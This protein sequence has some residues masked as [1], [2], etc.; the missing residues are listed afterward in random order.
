M[1]RLSALW[2]RSDVSPSTLSVD[3]SRRESVV[4][5]CGGVGGI[6]QPNVGLKRRGVNTYLVVLD[7]LAR[8]ERVYDSKSALVMRDKGIT[9][10][11]DTVVGRV[12]ASFAPITEI[13]GTHTFMNVTQR[14]QLEAA[15]PSWINPSLAYDAG[16][17]VGLASLRVKR[18]KLEGVNLSFIDAL[19]RG[20]AN[21]IGISYWG[22]AV[23]G[24]SYHHVCVCQML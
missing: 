3:V 15:C 1:A 22:R 2:S 4:A 24:R 6:V 12:W 11:E 18:A 21:F 14:A 17:S 7:L 5:L 8:N 9:S 13:R 16:L 19:A 10:M 20:T 23:C